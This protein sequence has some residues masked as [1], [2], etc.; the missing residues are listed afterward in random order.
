[1][2]FLSLEFPSP[3]MPLHYD[4]EQRLFPA[5]VPISMCIDVLSILSHQNDVEHL[6]RS[7]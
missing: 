1:M 4:L 2:E 3:F 6:E 7:L 5:L